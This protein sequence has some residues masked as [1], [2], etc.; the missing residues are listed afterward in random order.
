MLA[1]GITINLSDPMSMTFQLS[2]NSPLGLPGPAI[3]HVETHLPVGSFTCATVFPVFVERYISVV[4]GTTPLP[5]VDI[6]R[7]PSG[8]NSN[9]CH[10]TEYQRPRLVCYALQPQTDA[11]KESRDS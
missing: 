5:Y 8:G 1:N 10:D 11:G 4:L 7:I 9:A 3:G 6:E 2:C